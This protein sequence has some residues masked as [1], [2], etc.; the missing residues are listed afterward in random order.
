MPDPTISTICT[1][2]MM[3]EIL[4][5]RLQRNENPPIRLLVEP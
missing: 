3:A 5:A 4:L 2:E 1:D